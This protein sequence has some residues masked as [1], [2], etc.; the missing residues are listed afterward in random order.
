MNIIKMENQAAKEKMG[1]LI[2]D[3]VDAEKALKDDI[4]AE[5]C[6]KEWIDRDRSRIEELKAELR[7]FQQ[8]NGLI[9]PF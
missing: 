1:S 8:A 4:Q 6:A 2:R 3:I 9:S 5:E 7:E